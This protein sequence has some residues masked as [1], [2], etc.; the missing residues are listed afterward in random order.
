MLWSTN[1]IV[2]QTGANEWKNKEEACLSADA[3]TCPAR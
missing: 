3:A 1:L 2:L